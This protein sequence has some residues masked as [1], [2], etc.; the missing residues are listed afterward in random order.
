MRLH[1]G[2][3]PAFSMMNAYYMGWL[4]IPDKTTWRVATPRWD[5]VLTK[6]KAMLMID[7]WHRWKREYLPPWSLE[8][9]TVLDVGSGCG[10]TAAFYFEHGASTV[11][12]VEPDAL[13]SL[14]AAENARENHW[15]FLPINKPFSPDMLRA[16]HF[17]F[18][19][20][21]CEGCELPVL[22]VLRA[23]GKP[24]VVAIHEPGMKER[25][26]SIPA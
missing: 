16:Y 13:E 24:G 6:R 25:M 26:V 4:V 20:F 14:M 19:K 17:D 23:V 21:D 15:N 5:M 7:Q 8:G 3:G 12:G 2:L 22:E 1:L 11:I 9:K 10:E 18:F